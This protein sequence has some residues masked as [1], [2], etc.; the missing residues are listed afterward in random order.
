MHMFDRVCSV[1][2]TLCIPLTVFAASDTKFLADMILIPTGPF[3]MGGNA[4]PED[5]RPQH[6]VALREYLI[7]RNKVTNAQ[8]AGFINARGTHAADGQRWYDT[9]D[10]DARI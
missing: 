1:F 6:R 9:D 8:F 4:G 10:N 3:T 7:D 2:F 5:E